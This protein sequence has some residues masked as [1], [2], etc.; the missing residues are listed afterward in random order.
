VSGKSAP[1]PLRLTLT[2]TVQQNKMP[3]S[4]STS[5]RSTHIGWIKS[6]NAIGNESPGGGWNIMTA[7]TD[8]LHQL[9]LVLFVILCEL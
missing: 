1:N 4:T 8:L 7:V 3:I 2:L 5:T 9:S 6:D